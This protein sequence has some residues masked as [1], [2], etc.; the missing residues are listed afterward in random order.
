MMADSQAQSLYGRQTI[1]DPPSRQMSPSP[2]G[3]DAYGN[4]RGRYSSYQQPHDQEYAQSQ[5]RANS[6]Y[7]MDQTQGGGGGGDG[8]YRDERPPSTFHNSNLH[9]MGGSPLVPPSPSIN[10][11]PSLPSSAPLGVRDPPSDEELEA[12]VR[13]ILDRSDLNLVTKKG[14]RKEL[15]QEY[16]LELSARKETINGFIE[17]ALT[18]A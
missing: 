14:V 9:H 12:S 1:Y 7:G 15:E 3:L 16:G 4:E 13:R 11:L 2:S 18:G 6:F 17:A 5:Y 8:Y 10:L